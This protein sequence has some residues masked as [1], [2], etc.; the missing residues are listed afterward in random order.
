MKKRILISIIGITIIIGLTISAVYLN[1]NN[2]LLAQQNE[3]QVQEIPIKEQTKTEVTYKGS[4][5]KTAFALLQENTTIEFT[6]ANGLEF[7]TSINGVK[8][9]TKKNEYWSLNINNSPAFVGAAMYITKD[10]D[11]ITWKLDSISKYTEP[12]N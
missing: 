5:G 2:H 11:I 8:P 12:T 3:K 1:Q 7:V 9:D 10:T 4:A 6:G